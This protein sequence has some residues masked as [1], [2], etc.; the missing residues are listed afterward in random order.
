MDTEETTR[1]LKAFRPSQ[2]G[3]GVSEEDEDTSE[4]QRRIGLYVQRVE[5]RK[6][7]FLEEA[8]R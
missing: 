1:T 5:E 6:P 8:P 4:K 3:E 7:L 2:F